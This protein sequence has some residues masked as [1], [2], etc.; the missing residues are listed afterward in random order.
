MHASD[1]PAAEKAFREALALRPKD[2]TALSGLA[3][4]LLAQSKRSE[5]AKAA[6]EAL[7]ADPKDPQARFTFGFVMLK[8]GSSVDRA[9]K[10]WEALAKD[11]PDYAKKMG[12]LDMLAKI[13]EG[14]NQRKVH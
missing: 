7:A 12:V 10:E 8:T 1:P 14:A 11:E 5:A 3:Q 13:R 6:E 9:L 4:A 2:S